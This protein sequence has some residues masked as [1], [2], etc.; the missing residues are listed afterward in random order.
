MTVTPTPS[1]PDLPIAPSRQRPANF[2]EEMDD[3]LAEMEPFGEALQAIGAA[4]EANAGAAETA[5][6]TAEAAANTASEAAASAVNAPGTQATSTTSLTVGSGSKSLTLAQTGKAFAVG[7]PVRIARTSAA[8]TTWMQ[9]EISAF[10]SGAGAMTVAV[11]DVGSATG[12]FTDWTISL[13]GPNPLP[14]ATAAQI[15]AGTATGVAVSPAAQSEAVEFV[16]L[17][18]AST[19]AWDVAVI[20]PNARV[21]LGGNRTIGAPTNLLDGVT[22]TLNIN[23]ATY[24]PAWA[25]IWDFGAQGPPSLTASVIS[26]ITAQYDATAG[27]LQAGVWLGSA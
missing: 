6:G 21:T 16:A 14:A 25:S 9:G 5:A 11:S 18:D 19:V 24:T 17:T 27:K 10:D 13:T 23:P 20:G 22:Y 26:K 4:A 2:S 15:K 12:T 1:L 8:A 7:Q 3:F